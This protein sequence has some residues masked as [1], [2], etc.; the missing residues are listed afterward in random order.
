VPVADADADVDADGAW[1]AGDLVDVEMGGGAWEHGAK[2]LGPSQR[3]LAA[4]SQVHGPLARARTQRECE[5]E[6]RVRFA[7]GVE[8][9][10][11]AQ[12]FRR[13]AP[14]EDAEPTPVLTDAEVAAMR[15]ARKRTALNLGV[16]TSE[17]EVM[18]AEAENRE[19]E[20]QREAV[21]ERL[22]LEEELR[23]AWDIEWVC[24][25]RDHWLDS[26]I[27]RVT[28]S[29]VAQ[30]DLIY[31]TIRIKRGGISAAVAGFIYGALWGIFLPHHG[32]SDPDIIR[33][34]VGAISGAVAAGVGWVSSALTTGRIIRDLIPG[35]NLIGRSLRSSLSVIVGWMCGC[36]CCYVV[37]LFV[38]IVLDV[39]DQYNTGTAVVM[40]TG[41]NSPTSRGFLYAPATYYCGIGAP[42]GA[43]AIAFI[44]SNVRRERHACLRRCARRACRAAERPPRVG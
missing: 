35:S 7:N 26:E 40:G 3:E 24:D 30:K 20:E 22:D 32:V 42:I 1:R 11:W 36:M 38:A 14:A 6:M 31:M 19:K 9:D 34:V 12:D 27:E 10:W 16:E 37:G 39:V 21:E 4:V 43:I 15:A 13:L 18:A 33:T 44:Y 23:K 28:D 2:I 29:C 25:M 41:Y 17:E 8:S 5:G